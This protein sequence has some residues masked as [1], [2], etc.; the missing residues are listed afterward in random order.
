MNDDN[1][2][3]AAEPSSAS[4]GSQPVAWAVYWNPDMAPFYVDEE[5]SAKWNPMPRVV[6]LYSHPSQSELERIVKNCCE[7]LCRKE[8]YRSLAAEIAALHAE[9]DRLNEAI[10]R[11]ADQDAT[12]SVCDGDVT[13]TMDGTLTDEERQALEDAIVAVDFQVAYFSRLKHGEPLPSD[14][15]RSLLARL[16]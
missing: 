13:V 7:L 1:T 3:D 14:T 8:G 10:R 16:S 5:P 4:A 12:L 2:Q 9:N 6:P 11:L 15:L